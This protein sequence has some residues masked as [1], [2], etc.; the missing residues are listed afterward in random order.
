[1]GH[2][3]PHVRFPTTVGVSVHHNINFAQVKFSLKTTMVVDFFWS[4]QGSLELQPPPHT[5]FVHGFL[6]FKSGIMPV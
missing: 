3:R 4:F 6:R 5:F 2:Y 1:M